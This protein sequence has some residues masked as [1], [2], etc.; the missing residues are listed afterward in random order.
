MSKEKIVYEGKT[1]WI[2]HT[3]SPDGTETWETAVRTPGVRL[4]IKNSDGTYKLS[5]EF[6]HEYQSEGY[7]LPGG[8]VFRTL[9]EYSQFLESGKNLEDEIK[10]SVAQEA[11]EELGVYRPKS[12]KLVEKAVLGATVEWDL[13][14]FEVSGFEVGEQNLH[15]GEIVKPVDLTKEQILEAIDSGEFNEDRIVPVLLRYLKNN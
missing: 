1:F 11:E 14:V 2:K 5:R 6:R 8:K 13:Y 10:R 7:R 12:V 4:I 15:G 9:K 3:L